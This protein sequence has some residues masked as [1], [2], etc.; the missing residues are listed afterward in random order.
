MSV[1]CSTSM[2]GLSDPV[3]LLETLSIHRWISDRYFRSGGHLPAT[4]THIR[5]A[6]SVHNEQV[7]TQLRTKF[8]NTSEGSLVQVYSG[9]AAC[10]A[11]SIRLTPGLF[12]WAVGS[13]SYWRWGGLTSPVTVRP[14]LMNRQQLPLKCGLISSVIA[15]RVVSTQLLFPIWL[16]PYRPRC[17]IRV[18]R[19]FCDRNLHWP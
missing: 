10:S 8:D 13:V 18:Y 5:A 11:C 1:F 6:W 2:S 14:R 3:S 19:K 16:I 7:L 12:C 4:A 9:D 17:N 15:R